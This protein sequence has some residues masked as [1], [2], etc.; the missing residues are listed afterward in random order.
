MI[1]RTVSKLGH[2]SFTLEESG[3]ALVRALKR[4]AKFPSYR[5]HFERCGLDVDVLSAQSA[6][7]ALALLTPFQKGDYPGLQVEVFRALQE[8]HFMTDWSSGSTTAPILKFTS[9]RDEEVESRATELAFRACGL[10]AGDSVACLDVGASDIYLFYAKVLSSLGIVA[11]PFIKATNNY[12]SAVET[13]KRI[14]PVALISVPSV[15]QHCIDPLLKCQADKG[16]TSLRKV[17]Y[18]GEP[19]DTRLRKRIE[20][21]FGALCYSFYGTT[22]IGMVGI[23]CQHSGGIHVPLDLLVPTLLPHGAARTVRR[24]SDTRYEGVV[25]WTSLGFRDQ[26][27]ILYCV[28]DLVQ[29][30]IAECACGSA[31]PRMYFRRRTDHTFSLFGLTFTYDL[32]QTTVHQAL[33]DSAHFELRVERSGCGA[34]SLSSERLVFVLDERHMPKLQLCKRRVL[35]IYPLQ[36]F[37]ERGLLELSFDFV[38]RQYFHCRK[39]RSLKIT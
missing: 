26:P 28:N 16:L 39:T 6:R 1:I 10:S 33:G 18:I 15:L 11:V 31:L 36:D 32:F 23:E 14:D 17:I 22:E 12:G 27:L 21:D 3:S 9:T 35:N 7:D 8:H 13:L 19:M 38:P 25:A 34:S 24:V 29:L 5:N 30:D 2:L 4:A 20:H 37:V